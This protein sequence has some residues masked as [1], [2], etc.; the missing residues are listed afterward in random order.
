MSS[1]GWGIK[2][3]APKWPS[4]FRICKKPASGDRAADS[5]RG[6]T[7]SSVPT[8]SQRNFDLEKAF[9]GLANA[10][11]QP[12]LPVVEPD[13]FEGDILAYPRWEAQ[14]RE[15]IDPTNGSSFTK[16]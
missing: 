14:V 15:I 13:I 6:A 9:L 1:Q 5:S 16:L 3:C 11:R 8:T 12:Q 10:M 7:A 2:E 4:Y